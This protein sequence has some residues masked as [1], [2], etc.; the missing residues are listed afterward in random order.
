MADFGFPDE[1]NKLQPQFKE[2]LVSL[3]KPD[4]E[5]AAVGQ[6]HLFPK[7]Y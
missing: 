2:E 4:P 7:V 5:F 3:S 6:E 1:M